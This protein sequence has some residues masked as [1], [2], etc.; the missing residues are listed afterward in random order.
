MDVALLK[1]GGKY[2]AEHVN[3]LAGQV[4]RWSGGKARVVCYTEDPAGVDCLTEPLPVDLYPDISGWWWK[5]WVFARGRSL[6]Y[7]DLDVTVIGDPSPLCEPEGSWRALRDPWRGGF[8]TSV[9]RTRHDGDRLWS[10]FLERRPDRSARGVTGDQEF[11]TEVLGQE[12]DPW[13]YEWA[14]SYKHHILGK[15]RKEGPEPVP[16]DCRI[17]YF[18]GNPKPWDPEVPLAF[19]SDLARVLRAQV[20]QS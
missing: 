1:H 11:F 5:I 19:R 7:L 8:N 14:V 18:H 3:R 20:V 16:A 10:K 17:V 12:V 2:T 9:V 4:R 6:L 15:K 13:P